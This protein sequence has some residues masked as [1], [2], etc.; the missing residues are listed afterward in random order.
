VVGIIT[1]TREQ[2]MHPRNILRAALCVAAPFAAQACATKGFVREQI[3]ATRAQ[4]DSALAYERASRIEADNEQSARLTALRADLDSLRTTFGAKIAVIENGIRFAMP[5]TFAFDDATI[6]GTDRPQLERFARVAQRY[7]PGAM[8]TVEG[9][10]DPAG[11]DR[12]NLALSRRRADNV[13]QTLASLGVPSTQLRTVGYGETRLVAPGATH[14]ERGAEQN[15]R[16]VF[17]IETGAA[18]ANMV[19]SLH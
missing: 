16:V 18:E 11:S 14:N 9:F 7:Y 8:I 13:G 2:P 3:A 12:Y 4:S 15:R 6:T 10:A 17:V 19:A 1:I 5:V